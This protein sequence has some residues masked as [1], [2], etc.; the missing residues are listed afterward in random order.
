MR[1]GLVFRGG[2]AL[3]KLFLNPASRYSEDLD[4]VFRKSVPIGPT[5]DAIRSRLD[6]LLGSPKRQVTHYGAKIIYRY[7]S[8]NNVPMKL[9]IEINTT[10]KF[11]ILEPLYKTFAIESEWYSGSCTITTHKLEELMATKLRALYQR[12]KGRDLFDIA[13]VFGNNLANIQLTISIFNKYIE[14]DGIT[15]SG[16]D[17]YKNLQG[18][19][20]HEG[21]RHDMRVLLPEPTEW[22]FD[23]AFEF[24]LNTIVTKIP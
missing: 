2:T 9:K 12:R 14:R 11:G 24:V 15:I 1:E 19:L 16:A 6:P 21:F 17:F 8:E 10:E 3:N 4:F 13:H 5:L 22:D 20:L 23:E 7:L 18:N